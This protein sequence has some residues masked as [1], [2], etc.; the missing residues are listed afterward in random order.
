MGFT[1]WAILFGIHF[2]AYESARV[3]VIMCLTP[4]WGGGGGGGGGGSIVKEYERGGWLDSLESGIL[5]GKRY[6][7]ILQKY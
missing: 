7:G 1:C 5:V 3:S 6:F 2:T 4:K